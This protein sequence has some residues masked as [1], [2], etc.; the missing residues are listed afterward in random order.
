[1]SDN[2]KKVYSIDSGD[3]R[4]RNNLLTLNPK[5]FPKIKRSKDPKC[6]RLDTRCND[7]WPNDT[8]QYNLQLNDNQQNDT[9]QNATQH[10]ETQHNG[11]QHNNTRYNSTK[12][13][14]PSDNDTA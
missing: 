7:S 1:M 3:K 6:Q 5:I 13:N 2:G 14:D 4:R 11:I 12:H 10:N 8:K 9:Y